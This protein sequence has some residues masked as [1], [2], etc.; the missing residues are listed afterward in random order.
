MP[1]DRQISATFSTSNGTIPTL[2]ESTYLIVNAGG[3]I[4]PSSQ[5]FS[6]YLVEHGA[7]VN[8]KNEYGKTARWLAVLGHHAEVA[9]FLRQH[10]AAE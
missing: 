2:A 10:G 4:V 9:E 3:Q 5:P 8:A 6:H 1:G 7:D